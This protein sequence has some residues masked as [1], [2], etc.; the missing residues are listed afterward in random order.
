MLLA[1]DVPSVTGGEQRI[2]LEG[3]PALYER[4]GVLGV[5]REPFIRV[6]GRGGFSAVPRMAVAQ[7]WCCC[8]ALAQAGLMGRS[9]CTGLPSCRTPPSLLH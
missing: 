2:Y 6:R 4:G 5:L 3:G 8:P 9:A 7:H 1:V